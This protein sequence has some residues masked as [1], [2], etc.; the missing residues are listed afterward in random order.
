MNKDELVKVN[1][2]IMTIA[3]HARKIGWE[4]IS[5]STLQRFIYLLKVLY[6]FINSSE[7]NLFNQYHFNVTTFGPYSELIYRSVVF[8]LSTRRLEGDMDGDVKIISKD[9]V[10]EMDTERINWIDSILLILG[11]YGENKIFG[12]IVNDPLYDVSVKSNLPSE[13][14]VTSENETLLVLNDFKKAFEDTLP[15]TTSI[16]KEEYIS[17]YFD[18]IFSQIIKG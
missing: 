13:I 1:I 7:N 5:V 16:S 18:Y 3:A 14:Q 8:L 12:F 10:D 2:D 11:K 17:L 9:G 4:T 15:D 6:S